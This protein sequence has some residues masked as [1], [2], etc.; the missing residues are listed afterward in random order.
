MILQA[1]RAGNVY[2]AD[3]T[4]GV[5]LCIIIP[6][7][8]DGPNAYGLIEPIFEPFRYG[9]IV[10]SVIQGG[11]VNC[12][13]I[14][15]N[16][17]GNGTHTECLGHVTKSH[18]SLPDKLKEFHFWAQV[19]SVEP[20]EID[21]LKAITR[22][23]LSKYPIEEGIEALIVRTLP[24]DPAKLHTK[25]AGTSPPFFDA[26]AMEWM[27]ENG[28][29][30][31]LTDLPSVDPEV[32]EGRLVAHRTFWGLNGKKREFATI[33]ELIFVPDELEDGVVLLNLMISSFQSD[34]VPS[35]PIAYPV[36][37]TN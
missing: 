2:S 7:T 30:H 13:D 9:D 37:K 18:E 23:E 10:G 26:S 6:N 20:T 28:I 19:V 32:D 22:E 3:T 1:E 31:L 34:A 36:K 25:Y 29:N 24:N 21:G 12:E 33:T 4:T 15:F 5:S 17:H 27:V 35:T 14:Q 11:S 16:A 8:G